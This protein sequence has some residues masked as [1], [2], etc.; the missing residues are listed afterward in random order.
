M[1]ALAMNAKQVAW[2]LATHA[3]SP[4]KARR[5]QA[6]CPNVTWGLGLGHECDMLGIT[7]LGYYIEAEIKI[8]LADYHA[9]QKK[10][11]W[12]LAN[13]GN[14]VGR[15]AALQPRRYYYVAPMALA[16]KI[17]LEP[18]W[19]RSGLI[20][21]GV[22]PRTHGFDCEVLREAEINN[23]ATKATDADKI[24]LLRLA[25]LRIWGQ[26]P[27]KCAVGD[28]RSNCPHVRLRAKQEGVSNG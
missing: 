23:D 9:D 7:A 5:L 19:Q 22:N 15:A 26:Y 28:E 25:A 20:G 12:L 8:S 1:A 6:L 18:T 16:Q 21:V 4:F 24:K 3:Y 17:M 14:M 11:R 13:T 2:V 27:H 10:R